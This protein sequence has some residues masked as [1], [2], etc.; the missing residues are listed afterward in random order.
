MRPAMVHEIREHAE[1]VARELYGHAADGNPRQ[2]RVERCGTMAQFRR[3]LAGGAP[4]E[5]AQPREHL[6]H[7]ERLCDVVVRAAVDAPHLLV[8]APAIMGL[9]EAVLVPRS[10]AA[11]Q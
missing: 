11:H 8:P 9:P 2:P 4:D 5:R 10:D 7:L 6:L 3:E 1:L